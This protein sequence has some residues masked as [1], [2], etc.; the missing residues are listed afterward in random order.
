[1]DDKDYIL[2]FERS[3]GASAVTRASG[4]FEQVVEFVSKIIGSDPDI[5]RCYIA[6][7]IKIVEINIV[8]QVVEPKKE[9]L[10]EDAEPKMQEG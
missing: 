6:E 9:E 4:T 10:K 7:T 1:M 5:I 3:D 2:V 8:D